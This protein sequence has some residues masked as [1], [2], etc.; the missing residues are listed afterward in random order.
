MRT[1]VNDFA[2]KQLD[3]FLHRNSQVADVLLG[4]Q[5]ERDVVSDGEVGG[6]GPCP[7]RPCRCGAARA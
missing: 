3:N 5:A 1:F 7:G 6:T 4:M 2:E